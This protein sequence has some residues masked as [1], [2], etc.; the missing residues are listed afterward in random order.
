MTSAMR[1]IPD[2]YLSLKEWPAVDDAML[3]ASDQRRFKRLSD[4]VELYLAGHPMKDVVQIAGIGE[5]RFHKLITRCLKLHDDGR[6][7]GLRALVTG[8]LVSKTPR[9]SPLASGTGGQYGYRGMFTKFMREHAEIEKALI[10][11][12]RGRGGKL[13]QL[14]KLSPREVFKAFNS[15]CGK[16]V[17]PSEYPLS[18][19]DK[20]RRALARWVQN[21]YAHRYAADWIASKFGHS[22]AQAWNYAEGDG[23]AKSAPEPYSAWQIDE[24]TID[25][26]AKFILPDAYGGWEDMDVRRPLALRAVDVGTGA[27]IENRLVLASQ[28]SAEDMSM[29]LWDAIAGREKSGRVIPDL[30][31]GLVEGA[32][33]PA[34]VIPELRFAVPS[35]IYLDNALAHLADH[36]QHVI[37][38]TFGGIVKLGTAMTPKERE[39]VEGEFSAQARKLMRKLPGATGSNPKDPLREIAEVELENR[40]DTNELEQTIDAYVANGNALPATRSGNIPP[41]VRLRRLLDVGVL[42][43]LYLSATKRK[44]H[45]F[46]KS[47]RVVVHV[48]LKSGRRPYI[49]FLYQRYSSNFMKAQIGLKGKVLWARADFRNLQ[50]V[51]LFNE[52]GTEFGSVDV[53]GPWGKFP[54]D[55]RIRKLFGRLK[56]KGDLGEHAEDRPLE[57]LFAYLREHSRKD[58]AAAQQLAYLVTYL[59]R[60]ISLLY[61][62]IRDDLQ[63]WL[64]AA[65]A[66]DGFEMVPLDPPSAEALGPRVQ[67]VKKP[68]AIVSPITSV[69]STNSD[70]SVH[71]ANERSR[72]HPSLPRRVSLR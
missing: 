9:S 69:D 3:P 11:A 42:K 22:T 25:V 63:D 27:K 52:D 23:Q 57:T 12:L 34:S 70:A 59:D 5:R 20:G 62:A 67:A 36:V 47:Q 68:T 37:T 40:I 33:Y 30:K 19:S 6:I 48:D 2:N 21:V 55:V 53:L 28:A 38:H 49:N 13:A 26:E 15:L 39:T 7:W 60:N 16:F 56:R 65:A 18:T 31:S 45:Y 4:G 46:S 17:G 41:F 50:S 43:P 14:N 24:V 54:H 66:A 71:P 58:R 51:L 72:R 44:P 29:L 64:S 32:G 35:I 10:T 8:A 61:P 1:K